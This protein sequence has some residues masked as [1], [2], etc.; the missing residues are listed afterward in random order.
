MKVSI[1]FLGMQRLIAKT[2]GI[3]MPIT[4]KTSIRDVLE[5]VRQ[6]FPA[7]HLEAGMILITVNHEMASLDKVLKTNDTVSFLPFISGG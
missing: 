3:E 5:F 7:L 4:E 6:Q 2:D 1:E